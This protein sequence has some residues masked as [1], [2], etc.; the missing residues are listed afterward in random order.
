MYFPASTSSLAFLN[1]STIQ[2]FK[3]GL[4]KSAKCNGLC[5]TAPKRLSVGT[6]RA[7]ALSYVMGPKP[8]GGRRKPSLVG[9]QGKSAD[10]RFGTGAWAT[11]PRADMPTA[12]SRLAKRET[13]SNLDIF[14][15]R[16]CQRAT[17]V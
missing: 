13:D 17:A 7:F 3:F 2:G 4:F 1:A 8:L 15:P 6:I 5:K 14:S 11:S 10:E 12:A 16:V 9:T